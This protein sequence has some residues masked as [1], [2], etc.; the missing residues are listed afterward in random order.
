MLAV[1]VEKGRSCSKSW[2]FGSGTHVITL[3][4]V[5]DILI[6]G[7]KVGKTEGFECGSVVVVVVVVVEEIVA[8]VMFQFESSSVHLI[9]LSLDRP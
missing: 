7:W 4:S 1:I 9:C 3:E 8:V 6:V 2:C 5:E